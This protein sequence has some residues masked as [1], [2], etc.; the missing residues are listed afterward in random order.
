ME[1][2]DNYDRETLSRSYS[3]SAPILEKRILTS[4]EQI[5]EINRNY[6]PNLSEYQQILYKIKN[7]KEEDEP[8]YPNVNYQDESK[9]GFY[10]FYN[11]NLAGLKDLYTKELSQLKEN[12]PV[13]L[14]HIKEFLEKLE[15]KYDEDTYYAPFRVISKVISYNYDSIVKK[16][17]I[18]A[19]N[20]MKINE[21]ETK[22]KTDIS[23]RAAE[24]K[25]CDKNIFNEIV[26]EEQVIIQKLK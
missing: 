22:Y 14:Y 24:I 5:D 3:N 18:I 8:L 20:L 11:N 17:R 7:D 9:K 2:G 25:V 19:K 13:V 23:K 6:L 12:H 16:A 4:R 21:I 1:S 15:D 26:Y 10:I